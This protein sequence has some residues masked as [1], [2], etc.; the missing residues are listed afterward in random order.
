MWEDYIGNGTPLKTTK[1]K[2]IHKFMTTILKILLV[3][4]PTPIG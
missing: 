2:V 1:K 4:F 3:L